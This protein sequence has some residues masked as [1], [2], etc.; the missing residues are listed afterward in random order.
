MCPPSPLCL[1]TMS[2]PG[3]MVVRRRAQPVAQSVGTTRLRGGWSACTGCRTVAILRVE[4]APGVAEPRQ[5]HPGLEI[6][7]GLERAGFV[8]LDRAESIAITPDAAVRVER[9]QVKAL[10][11]G[12]AREP[13]SVLAVLILDQD[14]PPLTTV[15]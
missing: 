3:L 5:T 10:R 11:N 8:E 2:Q 4:L 14:R 1:R 12:S 7:Y 6:R 15:D 9:G 13:F